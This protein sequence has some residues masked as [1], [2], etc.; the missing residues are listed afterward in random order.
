MT[1]ISLVTDADWRVSAQGG[2]IAVIRPITDSTVV[3]L[4]FVEPAHPAPL[5]A[6]AKLVTDFLDA[7]DADPAINDLLPE[8]RRDLAGQLAKSFGG[9]S[10]RSLR[11]SCGLT[12][13]D[14]AAA[15]G[16][17]QSRVSCIE[18]RKDR[19]G[20]V[21]LRSMAAVLNVDFNTLMDALAHADK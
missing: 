9:H 5:P 10:L 7:F 11:L 21:M 3:M 4:D 1:A 6:G 17:S 15:L 20:E 16:T 2:S 13:A 12:Q 8:A 19:P 18:S 14:F